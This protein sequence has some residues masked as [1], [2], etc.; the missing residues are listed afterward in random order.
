[1]SDLTIEARLV[2]EEEE[3]RDVVGWEGLYEVSSLGRVRSLI[4]GDR[5]GTFKREEPKVLKPTVVRGY[6]R[7]DLRHPNGTMRVS[8]LV[9][10]AF[11]RAPAADEQAAHT[12]GDTS[13]NRRDNLRW[14]N[15]TE[16]NRDKY[17]HDTMPVGSRHPSA[18]L[19]EPI[20]REARSR[21]AAGQQI[22]TL[23]RECGVS[24]RTMARA[25]RGETWKHA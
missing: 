14:A 25:L 18:K 7:V 1:M 23:A 13:N 11:D 3:W 20:V 21:W 16:N 24:E 5:R 8:R 19:T 17:G 12:D 2:A 9:L 22:K 6:Q 4:D 10:W 15:P